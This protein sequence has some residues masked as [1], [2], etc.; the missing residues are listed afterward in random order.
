MIVS[1]AAGLTAVWL[2]LGDGSI[3]SALA[4]RQHILRSC[5]GEASM[6]NA[7]ALCGH[8]QVCLSK[9]KHSAA[10]AREHCQGHHIR[11]AYRNAGGVI[12]MQRSKMSEVPEQRVH[13]GNDINF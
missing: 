7:L 13:A 12:I 11:K 8:H 3:F 6:N 10:A 2:K 5:E 1:T 4:R 9:K